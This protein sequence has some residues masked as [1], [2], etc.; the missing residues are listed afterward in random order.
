MSF[1]L[2]VKAGTCM[3]ELQFNNHTQYLYTDSILPCLSSTGRLLSEMIRRG[4]W[5]YCRAEKDLA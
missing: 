3:N 1:S 2:E 5:K 4:F